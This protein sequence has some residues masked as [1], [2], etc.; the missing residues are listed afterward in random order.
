MNRN[1]PADERAREIAR[2]TADANMSP[3]E[4]TMSNASLD[5]SVPETDDGLAGFDSRRGGRH[6]LFAL[7]PGYELVD[8]GMAEPAM[9]YDFDWQMHDPREPGMPRSRG[10]IHYSLNHMRP[11]RVVELL[12]KN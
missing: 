1:D 3:D 10:R 9:P 6:L 4:D 8:K 5:S 2:S 7:Q 11:T 12:R